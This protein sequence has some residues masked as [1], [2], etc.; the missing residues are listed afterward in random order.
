M[1]GTFEWGKQRETQDLF[2]VLG[3]SLQT[4][5]TLGVVIYQLWRDGKMKRIVAAKTFNEDRVWAARATILHFALEW[6]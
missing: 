4:V 3:F 1:M 5:T 6:K 2:E